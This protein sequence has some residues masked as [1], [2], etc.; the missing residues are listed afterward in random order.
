MGGNAL[1]ERRSMAQRPMQ[2]AHPSH[3]T[4]LRRRET[5][6][7]APR[8]GEGS[9]SSLNADFDLRASAST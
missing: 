9:I 5:H 6:R 1:I 7:G 4:R 8:A 2:A 3:S